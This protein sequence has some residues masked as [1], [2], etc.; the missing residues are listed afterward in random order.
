MM[1]PATLA[2]PTPVP[3]PQP[4]IQQTAPVVKPPMPAVPPNLT[5]LSAKET[6]RVQYCF[7]VFPYYQPLCD[8][9]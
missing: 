2:V 8:D 5:E 9:G 7:V 6:D 4:P 3:M 1:Q